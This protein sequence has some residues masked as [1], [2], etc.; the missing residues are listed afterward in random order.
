LASNTTALE[1]KQRK[2][3]SKPKNERPE[4]EKR[5]VQHIVDSMTFP[6]LMRKMIEVCGAQRAIELLG[7]ST[8]AGV[9]SELVSDGEPATL[10]REMLARG[11]TQASLYRALQDLRKFGEHLEAEAAGQEV[12]N[13]PAQDHRPT[14]RLLF[15]ISELSPH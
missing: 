8:V 14:V 5:P 4:P 6:E 10:R 15:Q 13:W 1:K 9:I 7:W 2:M 12:V 11:M 3:K